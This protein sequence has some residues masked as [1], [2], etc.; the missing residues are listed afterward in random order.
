MFSSIKRYPRKNT[1]SIYA[2][3]FSK[4]FLEIIYAAYFLCVYKQPMFLIEAYC[5][6]FNPKHEWEFQ[7]PQKQHTYKIC[8]KPIT[9]S[10][11]DKL[12]LIL[13]VF[14]MTNCEQLKLLKSQITLLE[15]LPRYQTGTNKNK[16]FLSIRYLKFK[17]KRHWN[18]ILLSSGTPLCEMAPRPRWS[19]SVRD[20]ISL[21]P[22]SAC[23]C[24]MASATSAW[25]FLC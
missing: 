9:L 18:V 13:R 21:A 10:K 3:E 5:F 2:A 15:P 20:S 8:E 7:K 1:G 6:F 17:L 19:V 22:G 24:T 11:K 14:M 12:W 4:L 16:S 23:Y 25:A